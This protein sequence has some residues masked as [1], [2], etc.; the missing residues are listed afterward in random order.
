VEQSVYWRGTLGHELKKYSWKSQKSVQ[1]FLRV[2]TWAA[3]K[4]NKNDGDAYSAA[5]LCELSSDRG[6]GSEHLNQW[7][8]DERTGEF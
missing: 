6:G 3:S 4:R 1:F 2:E 7:L 5:G 8:P